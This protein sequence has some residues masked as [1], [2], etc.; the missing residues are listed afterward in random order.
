MSVPDSFAKISITEQQP[1]IVGEKP[2][3]YMVFSLDQIDLDS[4]SEED[5]IVRREEKSDVDANRV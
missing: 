2:A 4:S 5:K 1:F 3:D